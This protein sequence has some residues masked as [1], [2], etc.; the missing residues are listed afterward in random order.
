MYVDA[1][2]S[3]TWDAKEALNDRETARS[4]YGY[5]ISYVRCPILW[6]SQLQIKVSLSSTEIKY[7]GLSHSLREASPIMELLNEMKSTI[8]PY[9]RE[10]QV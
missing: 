6:K 9:H 7:T 1:E 3:G 4:R 8:S 2:F 5:I 10:H